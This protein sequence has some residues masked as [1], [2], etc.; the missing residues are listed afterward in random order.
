MHAIRVKPKGAGFELSSDEKFLWSILAT[1]V[2]IGPDSKLYVSDWVEGWDG[3]GKGRIYRL[4]D[5]QA[6]ADPK[7]AEVQRLI[8][9]D[10]SK[11]NVLDLN[12]ML[13]HVDRRIR[14]QAQFELANRGLA[15]NFASIAINDTRQPVRFTLCGASAR[16]ARAGTSKKWF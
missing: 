9:G 12:E 11:I 5:P 15:K 6:N 1:D 13:G 10:W 2:D 8:A 14:Q 4:F 16:S 3:A 7:V